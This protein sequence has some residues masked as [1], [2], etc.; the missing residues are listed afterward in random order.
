MFAD[1]VPVEG[2]L[3]R[4]PHKQWMPLSYSLKAVA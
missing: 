4:W 3:Y 2:G 1:L